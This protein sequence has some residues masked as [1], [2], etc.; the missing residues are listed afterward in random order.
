MV[1]E[2][3]AAS[4]AEL[5]GVPAGEALLGCSRRKTSDSVIESRTD[6]ACAEAHG[7]Y[8]WLVRGVAG[9]GSPASAVSTD[10]DPCRT[11]NAARFLLQAWLTPSATG[12]ETVDP[13]ARRSGLASVRNSSFFPLVLPVPPLLARLDI[14]EPMKKPT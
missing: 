12:R 11:G 3:G 13:L 8:L 4:T 2:F 14:S 9:A 6:R 10:S 7:Q 5:G 1:G